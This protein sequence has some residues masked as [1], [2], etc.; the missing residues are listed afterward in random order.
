MTMTAKQI[1]EAIEKHTL[2]SYQ[3]EDENGIEHDR[4]VALPALLERLEG[5]EKRLKKVYE[6]LMDK[7]MT[8]QEGVDR[9]EVTVKIFREP[10]NWKDVTVFG[11]VF[12][13]GPHNCVVGCNIFGRT[14][15]QDE[16]MDIKPTARLAEWEIEQIPGDDRYRL[17]GR[18][19]AHN[20]I[21]DGKRVS[22]SAILYPPQIE[23][24][25][26]LRNRSVVET[27]NTRYTLVGDGLGPESKGAE[28]QS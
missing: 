24:L 18:V 8:L 17:T 25:R 27:L 3:E 23:V 12:M 5:E 6:D 14:R 1:V 9:G 4:L 15:L 11:D 19:Y 16:P 7:L 28:V 22:T 20:R 21:E 13:L 10:V 26:L 2:L